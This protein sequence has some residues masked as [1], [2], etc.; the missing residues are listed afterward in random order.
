[1][2]SLYALACVLA[3]VGA[4][5]FRLNLANRDAGLLQEPDGCARGLRALR[6]PVLCALDVDL[7]GR[8]ALFARVV[9][10]E[11]LDVIAATLGAG[12]R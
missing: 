2:G 3:S 10:A 5:A 1:M 8:F 6:E 4:R 7:E 9:V 11:R 12:R